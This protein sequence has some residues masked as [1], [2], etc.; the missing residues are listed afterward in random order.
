MCGQD[1][2]SVC[3]FHL[4]SLPLLQISAPLD[5]FSGECILLLP[6]VL[7]RQRTPLKCIKMHAWM[8]GWGGWIDGW[9]YGCMYACMHVLQIQVDR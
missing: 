8:D 9:M 2:F 5:S 6:H 4:G 7:I 3:W 1:S